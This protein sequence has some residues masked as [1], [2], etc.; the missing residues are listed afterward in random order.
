[1]NEL[2]SHRFF[3]VFEYNGPMKHW[4]CF[5]CNHPDRASYFVEEQ[6]PVIEGQLKEK[7]GGRWSFFKRWKSR[8][9]TLSGDKLTYKD[10]AVSLFI[11]SRRPSFVYI[12]IFASPFLYSQLIAGRWAANCRFFFNFQPNFFRDN[13]LNK[14]Q[15][16]L[17]PQQ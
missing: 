7:K 17:D 9:F 11:F 15:A 12:S 14:K 16:Q 4:G 2:R 8:Y 6:E 13:P 1:M 10:T 5:L 3:D